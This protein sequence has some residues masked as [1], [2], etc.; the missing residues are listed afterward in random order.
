MLTPPP[1]HHVSQEI[2]GRR[3]EDPARIDFNFPDSSNSE[4]FL[5]DST[6]ELHHMEQGLLSLSSLHILTTQRLPPP[7]E[8]P[9]SKG[10]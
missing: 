6:H 3:D 1:D 5:Y 8:V 2:K 7:R 9:L 10:S 4:W